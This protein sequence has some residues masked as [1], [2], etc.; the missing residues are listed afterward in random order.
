MACCWVLLHCWNA[1]ACC[2]TPG[3]LP[4]AAALLECC[5]CCRM[6]LRCWH[7]EPVIGSPT[8]EVTSEDVLL[9][10]PHA[11]ALLAC[12]WCCHMQLH[13]WHGQHAEVCSKTRHSRQ[14]SLGCIL[15]ESTV[16]THTMTVS[17]LQ[18]WDTRRYEPPQS[19]HA[20]CTN[21]LRQGMNCNE[22]C[23]GCAK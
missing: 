13:C 20:M 1:A 7:D 16:M 15:A 12:C 4:H 2:C 17:L 18:V 6:Q 21:R 14:G 23:T 22:L 8:S 3:N 19:L 10:R 5:W 11:A 9:V